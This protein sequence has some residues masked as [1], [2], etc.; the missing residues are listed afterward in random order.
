MLVE[1]DKQGMGSAEDG[2]DV[3]CVGHGVVRAGVG[4]AKAS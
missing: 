2:V 3:E 1:A 4:L